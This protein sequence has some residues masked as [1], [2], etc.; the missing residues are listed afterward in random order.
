MSRLNKLAVVEWDAEL[1]EVTLAD[2][3]SDIELGLMRFFAHSPHIAKGLM[4]FTGALKEH[5]TLPER[6]AE[7]VRL[8]IAFHNQC[9]SCMAIRYD[10]AVQDGVSEDVVCSLQKPAEAPDLSPAEKA[11]LRYAD[12]F[13]T[14]H[15]A[16]GDADYAELREYFSEAQLV[17]L[18][19][20]I[21]LCV[22][23]GRLAATWDMVEELPAA[24]QA[25]D[26]GKVAPWSGDPLIIRWTDGGVEAEAAA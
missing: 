23:V 11:A 24:F 3:A 15:L 17:E 4:A 2:S 26:S 20:W 16:I 22:G 5:R 9:R 14:D 12:R 13:A 8:R 25:R 19:L 6:L 10:E 1:R 21:A 18:G 7:L